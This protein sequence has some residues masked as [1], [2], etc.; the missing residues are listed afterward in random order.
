MMGREES[1][2]VGMLEERW[3]RGPRTKDVGFVDA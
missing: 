3:R 1:K 2:E